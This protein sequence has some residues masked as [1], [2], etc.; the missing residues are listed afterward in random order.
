VHPL[1]DSGGQPKH[2]LVLFP[3]G[4]LLFGALR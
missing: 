4:G 2:P 1:L 3:L